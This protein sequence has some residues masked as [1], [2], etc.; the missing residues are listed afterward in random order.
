ML[1]FLQQHN[2]NQTGDPAKAAQVILRLAAMDAPPLRLLLG[3][4]A[5]HMAERVLAERQ[6]EDAAFRALS[7]STDRDDSPQDHAAMA[8]VVVGKS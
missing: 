2:G 6:A 5:V 4:D 1:A 3:S 7:L 8:A